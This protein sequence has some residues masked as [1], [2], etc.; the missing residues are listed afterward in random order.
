[1]II[2]QPGFSH[3]PD[4]GLPDTEIEREVPETALAIRCKTDIIVP[5][6]NAHKRKI[7][8]ERRG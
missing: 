8:D 5:N 2:S 1:M 7:H 3:K 6:G 4:S